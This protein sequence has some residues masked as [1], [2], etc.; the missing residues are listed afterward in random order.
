MQVG[1]QATEII[2]LRSVWYSGRHKT[3]LSVKSISLM[4]TQCWAGDVTPISNLVSGEEQ[5][6]YRS[7]NPKD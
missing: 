2:C 1:T 7:V 4:T 3:G 6:Q 5:Q